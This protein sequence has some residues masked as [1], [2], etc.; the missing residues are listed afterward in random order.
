MVRLA[1]GSDTVVQLLMPAM[2]FDWSADLSGCLYP[3]RKILFDEVFQDNA[4]GHKSLLV[5]QFDRI[6]ARK[7]YPQALN[8]AVKDW[9]WLLRQNKE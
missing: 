3:Y 6:L 8:R 1:I 9:Y 5:K 7:I 2:S 4:F